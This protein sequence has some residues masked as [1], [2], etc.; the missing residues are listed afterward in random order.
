MA[1]AGINTVVLSD[2]ARGIRAGAALLRQ[3]GLVAFPTETVYGLG[4]D[5]TD[6]RA[7]AR[8]FA[9]KGRPGFNP[10]IVHVA[11]AEAAASV[12]EMPETARRLA[13]AFWPG[14][15]TLVLKRRAGARLSELVT[16]GLPTVAVR[17]PAHPL[18]AA[19][20][21]GFG[22]PVAAPSANPSGRVSPTTREHVLEGLGG[23]IEAVFEGGACPVG[24]EST[25][26]AVGDDALTLLR[27]GAVP[28]EALEAAAGLP[29]R[30][31]AEGA[32]VVAPGG[33]ASHYA[34]RA[35]LRLNAEG[36]GRDEAWLGFGARES[37]QPSL[38]LSARGDLEEAAANLFAH[39][40]A[41]DAMAAAAG[42]E[43]IAVAPIP[44]EGIGVAINDRLARAA[45]PR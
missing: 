39:L 24:L 26:V 30:E 10:L 33:L 40:R 41:L 4:A 3:G 25:I 8:I 38:N 21:A 35:M 5:A 28:A 32:P 45:A 19:L 1:E 2:S 15:L 34:P 12:A 43:R 29:V 16:A 27:P 37:L 23:R 31:A 14:P 22:G 18:A 11:N 7:V 6:D 20:I 9:A 13:G 17:V 36:P 44:A 42:L